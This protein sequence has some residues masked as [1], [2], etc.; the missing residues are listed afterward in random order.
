MQ[1]FL[2]QMGA[3]VCNNLLFFQFRIIHAGVVN[4]LQLLNEYSFGIGDI[5][6]CDGTFLE[7]TFIHLGVDELVDK[8]ADA[9]FRIVGKGAR[10]CF[11]G[12]C[13]HQDGL[14]LGEGVWDQDR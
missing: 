10:G 1:Y 8:I 5:A 3:W 7:I 11:Y 4:R 6:E 13:H 9:L 2:A 14:F 12:I